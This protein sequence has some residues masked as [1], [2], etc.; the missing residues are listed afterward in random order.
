MRIVCAWCGKDMGEKDGEGEKGVTHYL[1]EECLT[2]LKA[3]TK[4]ETGD[5]GRAE[6]QQT[7]ATIS[8]FGHLA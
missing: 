3:K 8:I 1:C 2:K 4:N 7:K 5:E 6:K